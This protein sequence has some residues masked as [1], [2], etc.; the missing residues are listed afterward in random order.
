MIYDTASQWTT[1]NNQGIKN[2]E[3]IS[4]YDVAES[5]S[6]V[7]ANG[8]KISDADFGT[9]YMQGIMYKDNI[10]LAQ[11]R[12]DRRDDTGR[13]C[14]RGMPFLDVTNINGDFNANGVV[15]LAPGDIGT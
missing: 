14:V 12:N 3:L 13:M 6:A 10:C 4:N 9:F 8:N 15:G 7:Q 11:S 5:S 1:V 2:A